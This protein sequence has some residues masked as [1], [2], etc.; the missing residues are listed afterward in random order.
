MLGLTSKGHLS[1]GADADIT[2]VD[3]QKREAI[4][5]MV[6]GQFTSVNGV[7]TGKGGTILCTD[8]GAET[9]QKLGI[10]HRVV[11][12]EKSMLYRGRTPQ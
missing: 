3:L 12:L 9:C 1:R 11:D 7:I 8:R 5:T 2:I 6:S 4:A 10:N